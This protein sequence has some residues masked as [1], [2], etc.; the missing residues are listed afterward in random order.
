MIVLK[1]NIRR[2]DIS[3]NP[4]EEKGRVECDPN[5]SYVDLKQKVREACKLNASEYKVIKLRNNDLMIIPYSMMLDNAADTYIVDVTNINQ[6]HSG[7]NMLQD[8]YINSV[9]SKV[10]NMENRIQQAEELLPQ[11]EC[12][13]HAHL[14]ETVNTLSNKVLFLNRRFD[15]ISPPQWTTKMHFGM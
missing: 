13:Q 12:K 1:L 8:A 7:M 10:N 2:F 9:Y 4:I 3:E 6:A 15:E 5:I 14:E 11:L